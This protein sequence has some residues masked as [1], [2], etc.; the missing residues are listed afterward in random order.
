MDLDKKKERLIKDLI[1]LGALKTDKIISA[2]RKVKRE[3]FVLEKY[4]DYAYVDEPLPILSSQTISQPYTVAMMT[5]SLQPKS[6]QKILEIGT[7]SGYQAAILAEI[8]GSKGKIV[9]VERKK[10]LADFAG[11]NLSDYKNVIVI[12]DDGTLGC[13]KYA[14]YDRIIVTASSPDIP[15]PLIE[16][17]KTGG[18]MVIPVGNE[19]F[20]IRKKGR[21][22][23]TFIGYYSF[24]PLIGKY[25]HKSDN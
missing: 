15:K 6:G 5:E 22:E 14:P 11:Q 20:V 9:T 23:K 24:V 25:G 12:E 17:L 21:I 13:E 1:S 8:V 16:Q 4:R 18:M 19:M 2:F 10:E 3:G 7:G